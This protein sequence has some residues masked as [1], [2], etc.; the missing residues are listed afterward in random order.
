MRVYAEETLRD[1]VRPG[2]ISVPPEC[3]LREA[4]ERLSEEEIG[5]VVVAD[6]RGMVGV[7]SERDVITALAGG[8]DPD[9]V[10]VDDVMTPEPLCADIDDSLL[11][12]ADCMVNSNVRHLPILEGGEPI[13]VIS[14][15]DIVA[16]LTD[17]ARSA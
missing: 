13:S 11:F 1:L 17:V 9:V 4:A 10:E 6:Q 2:M 8:A 14:M 15:R 16:A 5:L 3:T 12:A 7:V